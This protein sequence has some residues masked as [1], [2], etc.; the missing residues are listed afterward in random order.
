MLSIAPI[1]APKVSALS[2]ALGQSNEWEA[3]ATWG[4]QRQPRA[5]AASP[6]GTLMANRYGHVAADKMAAARV[7][8]T[9]AETATTRAFKPMPRPSRARGYVKRTNAALTLIIPAAPKP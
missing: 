9:A 1:P 2:S 8:P 6:T 3:G 7:G 5:R 4:R